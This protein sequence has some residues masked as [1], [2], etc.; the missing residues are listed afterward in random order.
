MAKRVV[1]RFLHLTGLLAVL[2][3]FNRNKVI[4]LFLHGTATEAEG[5]EWKPLRLPRSVQ[6]LQRQ[7]EIIGRHY[8]WV[9]IDE[10]VAML[11]GK[12]KMRPNSVVLTF[13]DGYR[14]NMSEALP[15][16][17][18]LGI[19]STIYVA[20]GFLNNRKAFW[21]ERFDYAIQQISEPFVVTIGDNE[22]KF[23]RH[24]R[25]N[26]IRKYANLRA[27]AKG[28][29]ADDHEFV[30]FF[31]KTSATIEQQ[32]G[33]SIRQIQDGDKW[34]AT[35]SDSDVRALNGTD[36]VTIG[37]HTVDHN[38][39]DRVS[40]SAC[41][42]QL[43]ES[44]QYLERVTGAECRHFCYPNGSVNGD[45]ARLVAETAYK[46]AVTTDDGF[47]SVGDD[48]L[49]LRRFHLPDDADATRLLSMLSGFYLLR[50]RVKRL[51]RGP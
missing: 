41:R 38:R 29:F 4:I 37:S 51:F 36:H 19:K 34:S 47:N 48:L 27:Y 33:R 16:L 7:L 9:S 25:E 3:W 45:V 26:S 35:L 40:A 21:F 42:Q 39:L 50:D 44:K 31:D 30:D 32:F 23:L 15:V 22:Y 18:S 6:A 28:F 20:T 1:I 17:Q 46:S 43:V 12:T 24:D 10:A 14:N 8:S 13:D 11:S 5:D 49:L 2:R